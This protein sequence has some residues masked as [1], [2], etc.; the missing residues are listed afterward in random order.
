MLERGLQSRIASG[1]VQRVGV[2]DDI[3]QVG[4]ARLAGASAV[5]DLQLRLLG[6][7][8]AEADA[9]GEVADV[10]D[11]GRVDS[12]V[13]VVQFR[14]LGDE[15][16]TCV[17]TELFARDAERERRRVDVVMVFREAALVLVEGEVVRI[18]ESCG[19]F[20]AVEGDASDVVGRAVALGVFVLEVVPELE[21]SALEDRFAVGGFG[22][23]VPVACRR[24]RVAVDG[25][26]GSF[27]AAS[28]E[29]ILYA[30]EGDGFAFAVGVSCRAADGDVA[31]RASEP[32]VD[33]EAEVGVG[34]VAVVGG[35]TPVAVDEDV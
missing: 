35:D 1:D 19:Q 15:V 21:V 9:G 12:L 14:A 20:E 10:A 16:D 8:V 28:V 29:V 18:V 3:E 7:A 32:A 23:I 30:R 22:R 2:V 26:L 33:H 6:E 31:S 13:F 11:D 24:A 4:H 5:V 27:G 25:F 34:G 17:Q